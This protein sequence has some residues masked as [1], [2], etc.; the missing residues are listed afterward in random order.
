[1]AAIF[2]GHQLKPHVEAN[3]D[4][5]SIWRLRNADARSIVLVIVIES[6]FEKSIFQAPLSARTGLRGHKVTCVAV[7]KCPTGLRVVQDFRS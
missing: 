4:L 2:R 3:V 7:K 5:G 1:M 6:T